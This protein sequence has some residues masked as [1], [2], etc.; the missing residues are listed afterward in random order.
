MDLHSRHASII[1]Q[2]F[3]LMDEEEHRGKWDIISL[4]LVLNFIPEP[5]E[6]GKLCSCFR[7]AQ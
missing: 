2:D 3:L 5:K 6:R 1:Q 4:S 7:S